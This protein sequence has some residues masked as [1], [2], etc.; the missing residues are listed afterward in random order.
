LTP[1]APDSMIRPMKI[2]ARAVFTR[3]IEL[4]V[5]PL[6]TWETIRRENDPGRELAMQLVG[7]LAAVA[8]GCMFLGNLIFGNGFWYSFIY[9]VL[10]LGVLVGSVFF[11]GWLIN[12]S[13]P[14]FATIRNEDGALRLVA[15]SSI[16]VWIFGIASL[17]PY[18]L[19]PAIAAGFG[20]SA[21]VFYR[22]CTF[23]MDTPRERAL[24]FSVFF[25][26]SWFFVVLVAALVLSRIVAIIFAPVLV[27]QHFSVPPAG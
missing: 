22:G 4:M 14:S 11:Q 2:D 7:L 24:P 18:L 20:Y 1:P 27:A 15:Y 10:L 9:S 13:A 19:A 6:N 16:P 25:A 26:A 5:N 12:S 23:I 17:V 21:Y 8:C 3:S